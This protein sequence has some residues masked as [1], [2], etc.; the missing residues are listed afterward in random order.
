MRYTNEK[1]RIFGNFFDS[2]HIKGQPTDQTIGKN[3]LEI[4][5]NNRISG[6]DF[7]SQ[8]NDGAEIMSSGISGWA[9]F[10]KKQQ[11]LAKYTHCRNHAV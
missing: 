2:T 8:A 10:I 1:P 9:G 3:I 6:T 11:P 7:K 4:W 5:N